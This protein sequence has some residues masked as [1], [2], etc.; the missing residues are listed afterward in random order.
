MAK[1]E[2]RRDEREKQKVAFGMAIFLL[3]WREQFSAGTQ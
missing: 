1:S 3:I 2:K